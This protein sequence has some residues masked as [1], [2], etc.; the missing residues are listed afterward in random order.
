MFLL[1]I[2]QLNSIKAVPCNSFPKIFGGNAGGSYLYQI[3]VYNDY[4]AM[5]GYTCDNTLTGTTTSVC[6]PYVVL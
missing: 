4:L 6:I 1:I 5:G 3:D 2:A